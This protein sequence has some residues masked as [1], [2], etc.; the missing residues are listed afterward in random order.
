MPCSQI[1]RLLTPA[2]K[3]L[4]LRGIS[5]TRM[6]GASLRSRAPVHT[7]V[8]RKVVKPGEERV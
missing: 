5:M 4:E 3:A 2:W 1:D 8:D 7:Q 6:A